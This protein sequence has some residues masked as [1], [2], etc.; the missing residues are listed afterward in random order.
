MTLH[1]II[2]QNVR[3]KNERMNIYSNQAI[4]GALEYIKRIY[5]KI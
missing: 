4:H 3:S 1:I 2:K 5:Y